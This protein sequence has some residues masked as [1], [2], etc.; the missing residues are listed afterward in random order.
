MVNL[1]TTINNDL[2]FI[3]DKNQTRLVE[4]NLIIISTFKNILQDQII[5]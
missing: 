3:E 1:G 5:C 4:Q 2:P